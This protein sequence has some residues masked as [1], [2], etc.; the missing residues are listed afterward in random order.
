[1][2]FADKKGIVVASGFKLQAGALLDAR[3][4]VETISERDE[5]VTLNAVTEGLRV[6]VKEKKT[7]YEWNGTSWDEIAKGTGYT[8]PDSG[9]EAGTYRSVTV[10]AQGH[11]TDG[12]NP[13]TLQG[14]GITDAADKEHTHEQTD[15]EGLDAA[16]A[17]KVPTSRKI[18]N[19]PLSG[20]VTLSATD[21]GAIAMT[22]KGA[23]NGVASL[24]ENGKVPSAQLPSYV[25]DVIEGYLHTDGKFYEEEGHTTE[26]T[27]ESGKIYVDIANGKTY[28]WSG[29]AFVEISASLALGETSST[30]FAGDKGKSAYEHS[31]T[32]H[33][34]ANAEANVQSDWSE[35]DSSSDAYIKNKPT[36]LPADGGDAD[37]VSGH[38]VGV[39]VPADAK[40][41]D[42]VYTHPLSHPASMI[43]ESATKRFV[44]DTEKETWNKKAT[45]IFASEL[46]S[47][48][49]AGAICFLT[50]PADPDVSDVE[51]PFNE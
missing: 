12:T 49:P 5:L 13:T 18:N 17:G 22:D 51:D 1:M 7:S 32:A 21:V 24:D 25:D 36:A 33:A 23:S 31:Q 41:T 35:S 8:H 29:T 47:Q 37:T 20:D 11:V 2:S 43:T 26:V 4:Q 48:A 46:P 3:Q 6:Y 39:N 42:T 45:I 10:D 19:K 50:E 16:L 40:F 9:V 27:G 38:T 34:P 30:A 44:S 28:R 14:Y 15:I